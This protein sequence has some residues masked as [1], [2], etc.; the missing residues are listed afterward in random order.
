M[1]VDSLRE[2][3]AQCTPIT[4][5]A[6]VREMRRVDPLVSQQLAVHGLGVKQTRLRP[7]AL[8]STAYEEFWR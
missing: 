4:L 5:M 6:P 3:G 1:H 7:L 2:Q 8:G